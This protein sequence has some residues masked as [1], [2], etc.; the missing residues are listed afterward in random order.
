MKGACHR[1]NQFRETHRV[2]V[3]CS[4]EATTR[5]PNSTDSKRNNTLTDYDIYDRYNIYIGYIY[6]I[7][8]I[9]ILGA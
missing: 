4:E 8:M 9:Y 2:F 5:F 3:V 7:Y 6:D 1:K